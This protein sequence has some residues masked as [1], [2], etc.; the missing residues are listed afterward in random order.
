MGVVRQ[1]RARLGVVSLRGGH[2]RKSE[3]GV[4]VSAAER[5]VEE[6]LHLR[7]WTDRRFLMPRGDRAYCDPEMCGKSF[8]AQS[9]RRLKGRR[10]SAGPA[11]SGMHPTSRSEIAKCTACAPLLHWSCTADAW[12]VG[13][14][15]SSIE[16]MPN[17]KSTRR[18]SGL[19]QRVVDDGAQVCVN[20]VKPRLDRGQT[21]FQFLQPHTQGVRVLGGRRGTGLRRRLA[22]QDRMQMSSAAIPA[23][24]K[25]LRVCACSAVALP[26][27]AG[28]PARS[29]ARRAPFPTV[30]AV[31]N[32]AH[33]RAHRLRRPRPPSPL[34]LTSSALLSSRAGC[35]WP[36]AVAKGDS[37]LF[38]RLLWPTCVPD[39]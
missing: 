20:V 10:A 6:L 25:A 2:L 24:S 30:P 19:F 12:A 28:F 33:A 4:V 29:R 5:G 36:G 22:V 8:V 35:Y 26:R 3:S 7:P 31:A 39:G 38:T 18:T 32:R 14:E 13:R 1:W 34:T 16:S 9:Q 15:P 17:K 11:V 27:D 21:P 37:G 23:P